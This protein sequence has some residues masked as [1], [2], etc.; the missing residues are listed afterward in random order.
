MKV[1]RKGKMLL[2]DAALLLYYK[3]MLGT[4]LGCSCQDNCLGILEDAVICSAVASYLVWF[5]RR[6]KYE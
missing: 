1:S 6:S 4:R 3:M 2:S 5:E